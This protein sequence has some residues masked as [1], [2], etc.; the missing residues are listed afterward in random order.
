MPFMVWLLF[1]IEKS[2][3]GGPLDEPVSPTCGPVPSPKQP[4]P[5]FNRQPPLLFQPRH[6]R[7]PVFRQP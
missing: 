1:L 3:V 5:K 2:R 7:P 6:L 4:A